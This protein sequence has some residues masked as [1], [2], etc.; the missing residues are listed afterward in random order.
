MI[1]ELKLNIDREIE[2]VK[3]LSRHMN[4][5]ED[6]SGYERI[7]IQQAMN[8]A[9]KRAKMINESIPGLVRNVSLAKK[10]PAKSDRTNLEKVSI[11]TEEGD[12]ILV[13]DKKDIARY[14]KELD[15]SASLLKRLKKRK[16]KKK[17][18]E[19]KPGEYRKSRGYLRFANKYAL[20]YA[21]KLI[22]KGYFKNLGPELQKANLDVLF[23]S[24][25]SMLLF[26]SFASIFAG[27]ALT[28]FLLFFTL[29][30]TFPFIG[31]YQGGI[32]ARLFQ[33]FWIPIALPVI[34][35]FLLYSY[36]K[37]ERGSIEKKI[38]AELPFAVVHM[39][40]IA[41]SGIIPTKIFEI[42]GSSREYKY[43]GKEIRKI[44]NQ[45]NLYGYD[46]V[47]A[48]NNASKTAPSKKLAELFAGLSATI[49]TGGDLKEF[50]QKRAESLMVGYRLEREK[51]SKI[52][53]TFMD[54]YI[55]VVIATPMILLLLIVIISVTGLEVGL[56]A[57][58]LTFL[59]IL[60]IA[61]I[62]VVFMGVLHVKQPA[63]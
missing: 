62:N 32:L 20:G 34:T 43:L 51:F 58:T 38:D 18:K 15:I 1:P 13:I 14:L 59:I 35:F 39:S 9:G 5:A 45:I 52:A 27:A 36:P 8:S 61:I 60:A 17:E 54:I 33:V 3:E 26:T 24:Y 29:G 57:N 50:F 25:V 30:F 28:V 53:E 23:K 46:L 40:A 31:I 49:S 63:Y 55:S 21:D 56:G 12:H 11:K 37:I 16:P 7:L 10:L 22:K 2:S 47:T 48:L 41:G 42:I 19:F 44:L 4:D 6:S